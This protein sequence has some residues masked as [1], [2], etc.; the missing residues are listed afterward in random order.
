MSHS[1]IKCE[2]LVTGGPKPWD[3][4]YIKMYRKKIRKGNINFTR[5]MN[6]TISDEYFDWTKE[7]LEFRRREVDKLN[8]HRKDWIKQMRRELEIEEEKEMDEIGQIIYTLH[9]RKGY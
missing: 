2:I 3:L 7:E 6:C 5:V 4:E 8:T 1:L 9:Q